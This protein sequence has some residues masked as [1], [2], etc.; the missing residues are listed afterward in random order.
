MNL[1]PLSDRVV[2]K[3]LEAEETTKSGIILPTDSKEKPQQAE[4]VAVGPGGFREGEEVD[5][6]VEV[7]E[8]VIYS[9][10]AGTEVEFDDEKYIIVRQDDI[11]AVIDD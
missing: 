5:M 3:P 9:R 2:L 11:L 1:K 8:K 10:Y 6:D 7:G 4:I